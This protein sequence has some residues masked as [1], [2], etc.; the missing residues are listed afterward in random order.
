[1]D[2]I[3]AKQVRTRVTA[4]QS[5]PH[6]NAAAVAE[7]IVCDDVAGVQRALEIDG[8]FAD[9][10]AMFALTDDGM[11]TPHVA[12]ANGAFQVLQWC[13]Q[14]PGVTI[15]AGVPGNGWS[16]AHF[17]AFNGHDKICA[18]LKHHEANTDVV[19]AY[20]D[21]PCDV[22][23]AAGNTLVVDVLGGNF[24]VREARR[25]MEEQRAALLRE[26]KAYEEERQRQ[27]REERELAEQQRQHQLRKRERLQRMRELRSKLELER[28]KLIQKWLAS[29]QAHERDF[30]Q[31]IEW[32]FASQLIIASELIAAERAAERELAEDL[33]L[34]RCREQCRRIAQGEA[35]HRR[36]GAGEAE[37]LH[38]DFRPTLSRWPAIRC[39]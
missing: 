1:M 10:Y 5:R 7:A 11:A 34:Q 37:S 4:E 32:L 30:W 16:P 24:A 22:A 9:F 6:P 38:C 31:E 33:E 13:V 2:E 36:D 3:E 39:S 21:S 8:D 18:M 23:E 35:A 14:Q 12:A 26:A 19:D 27:A 29:R 17:A 28:L 15:D 25:R 20:G